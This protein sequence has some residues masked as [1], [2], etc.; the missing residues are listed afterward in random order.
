MDVAGRGDLVLSFTVRMVSTP[1]SKGLVAT[2]M[3]MQIAQVMHKDHTQNKRKASG[4]WPRRDESEL[5]EV[6]AK[7]RRQEGQ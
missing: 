1:G 2:S 3:V 7:E 5:A 4:K 6:R